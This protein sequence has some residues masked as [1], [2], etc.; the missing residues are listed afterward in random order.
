MPALLLQPRVHEND[1]F[2]E[3]YD[4]GRAALFSV[5]RMPNIVPQKWYKES[6]CQIG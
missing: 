2:R 1:R 4:D 3:H 6:T 5:V